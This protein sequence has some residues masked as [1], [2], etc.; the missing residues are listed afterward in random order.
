L[1]LAAGCATARP[2]VAAPD[3]VGVEALLSREVLR[4]G[5]EFR[6]V[7]VSRSAEASFHVALVGGAERPHRHDRHDGAVLILRGGG[8][9]HLG[10]RVAPLTPGDFILI[11]RGT[12]HWFVNRSSAPSAAWV[13]FTPPFDRSDV[14]PAVPV[15]V[16]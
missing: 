10:D 1:F 3:A 12:P 5:E 15:E 14:R 7:D 2:P 13:T 8:D 6:L 11:P 9:L 16:R 4:P